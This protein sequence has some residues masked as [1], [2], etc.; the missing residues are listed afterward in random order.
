VRFHNDI[1]SG[2]CT[3]GF[4]GFSGVFGVVNRGQDWFFRDWMELVFQGLDRFFRDWIGLIFQD[5]IRFSGFVFQ[6][7]IGLLDTGL[8]F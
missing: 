4:K 6:G 7:T 5:R 8:V 3:I 1:K 2:F